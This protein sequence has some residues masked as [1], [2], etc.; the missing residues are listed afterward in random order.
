MV[1]AAAAAAAAAS[2]A[3]SSIEIKSGLSPK[4]RLPQNWPPMP[5]FMQVLV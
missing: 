5:K 4:C 2:A 1:A 3:D